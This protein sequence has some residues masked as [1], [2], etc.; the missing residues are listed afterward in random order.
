MFNSC[1][2]AYAYMTNRFHRVARNVVRFCWD[3]CCLDSYLVTAMWVVF[4]FQICGCLFS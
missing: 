4:F 2:W 3:S 1:T